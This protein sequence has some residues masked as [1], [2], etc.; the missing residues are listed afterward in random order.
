MMNLFS[1]AIVVHSLA[2][3]HILWIFWNSKE[4]KYTV[5]RPKHLLQFIVFP[6]SHLSCLFSTL[7]TDHIH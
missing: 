3:S 6:L 5:L 7:V 4:I 1:I 2:L